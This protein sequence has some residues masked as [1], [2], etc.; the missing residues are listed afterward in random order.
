MWKV[1]STYGRL[2]SEAIHVILRCE[3]YVAFLSIFLFVLLRIWIGRLFVSIIYIET[4][5][6]KWIC[7]NENWIVTDHDWAQL[8][9]HIFKWHKTNA[10]NSNISF[11]IRERREQSSRSNQFIYF[12]SARHLNTISIFTR[13]K[14]NTWTNSLEIHVWIRASSF[15]VLSN[16]AQLSIPLN[17]WFGKIDWRTTRQSSI[18][19]IS[20]FSLLLTCNWL[21]FALS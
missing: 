12:F 15:A 18:K 19:T 5:Q 1:H 16:L 2:N 13:N 3:F 20:R 8:A 11:V 4:I 14:S 21:I 9:T 17:I 10:N 7:T 6:K